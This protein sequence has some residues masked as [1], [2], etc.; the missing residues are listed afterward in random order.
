MLSA[1]NAPV[2]STVPAKSTLAPVNVAAAVVPPFTTKF[3]PLF[4]NEPNVADPS[5]RLISPPSAFRIMSPATSNV[6]SPLERSISVPSMVMLSTTTPPLAVTAPVNADVPV[7][8]SVP[9]VATLPDVFATVNLSESIVRPPFKAVAPVTVRVPAVATFPDVSA[10]VNLL[11][12]IVRPPLRAVTPVTVNV[13]FKAVVP[14]SVNVPP[15]AALP[16]AEIPPLRNRSW[17]RE[18]L[19]PRSIVSLATGSI[20]L[21]DITCTS[22]RQTAAPELLSVQMYTRSVEVFSHIDPTAYPSALSSPTAGLLVAVKLFLPPD[23]PLAAGKYPETEVARGI[24]GAS[25]VPPV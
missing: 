21:P 3:P 22:S 7:T 13:E 12:S 6:R 10:T 9:A 2:T 1:V 8:A 19:E 5:C 25:P 23:P 14:V 16:V 17:K 18:P 4:V 20:A 24:F 11:L 15:T